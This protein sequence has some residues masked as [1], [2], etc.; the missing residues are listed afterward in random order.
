[1]T[2]DPTCPTCSGPIR[3]GRTYCSAACYN[4][5][6]PAKYEP[7]QCPECGAEF[8]R[9]KRRPATYRSN[10]CRIKATAR[11]NKGHTQKKLHQQTVGRGTRS[12]FEPL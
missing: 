10:P 1:M 6:A 2:T 5:R 4:H 9:F 12:V 3:P 11:Q 8:L 7:A